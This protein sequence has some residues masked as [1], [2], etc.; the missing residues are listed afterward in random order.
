MGALSG[1]SLLDLPHREA[2]RLAA[3]DRPVYLLVNPVEYHGPHLSLHNDQHVSLGLTGALDAALG[4]PGPPRIGR[5]AADP[6][7]PVAPS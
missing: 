1:P 7:P 4:H 5:L 6:L 2:R 3:E